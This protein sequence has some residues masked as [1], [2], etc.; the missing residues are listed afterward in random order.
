LLGGAAGGKRFLYQLLVNQMAR[1]HGRRQGAFDDPLTNR[2]PKAGFR[3]TI[4]G[5]HLGIMPLS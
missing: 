4:S 5:D 2:R 1:Q 3:S